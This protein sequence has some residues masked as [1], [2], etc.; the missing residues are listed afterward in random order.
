MIIIKIG[1]DIKQN[2]LSTE[3][4]NGIKDKTTTAGKDE[5]KSKYNET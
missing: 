5:K 1:G 3:F 4:S 2:T